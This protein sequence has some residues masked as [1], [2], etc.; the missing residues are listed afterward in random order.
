MEK[1]E[2]LGLDFNKPEN[3]SQFNKS[4]YSELSDMLE[5]CDLIKGK[6]RNK[7]REKLLERPIVKVKHDWPNDENSPTGR[8]VRSEIDVEDFRKNLDFVWVKPFV[9]SVKTPEICEPELSELLDS[10][11]KNG[12]ISSNKRSLQEK[13]I[14]SWPREVID[15]MKTFI[16]NFTDTTPKFVNKTYTEKLS[17]ANQ[18][19]SQVKE[20]VMKASEEG[21]FH[22]M[23]EKKNDPNL[24]EQD[25]LM[26]DM[27]AELSWREKPKVNIERSLRPVDTDKFAEVVSTA[28]TEVKIQK[29]IA[30][31]SPEAIA[32]AI[33]LASGNTVED[34]IYGL[35]EE[36][37][38]F[39]TKD[40]REGNTNS[41]YKLLENSSVDPNSFFS[42]CPCVKLLTPESGIVTFDT[43]HADA[44][45]YRYKKLYSAE[46]GDRSE[47]EV[48]VR[49]RTCKKEP[50][51]PVIFATPPED[52]RPAGL[53]AKDLLPVQEAVIKDMIMARVKN[54]FAAFVEDIS[55][56]I[57]ELLVK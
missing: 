20:T 46:D 14:L 52:K 36:T 25:K 45:W 12:M 54:A 2:Q 24:S 5:E 43:T 29:L 3:I 22:T 21:S 30:E 32:E 38:V 28:E 18:F 41:L 51:K 53:T 1:D 15:S 35:I 44:G 50:A 42:E 6:D 39:D 34:E 55:K 49:Y 10:L 47:Y 23:L 4:Y 33:K 40:I 57:T 19:N 31:G 9:S 26:V 17:I 13:L 8:F 27:S 11:I 48:T 37:V 7:L 56:D 16:N